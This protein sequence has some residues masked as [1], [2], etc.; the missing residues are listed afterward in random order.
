MRNV[1]F[2][3]VFLQ[4]KIP[5]LKDSSCSSCVSLVWWISIPSQFTLKIEKKKD[6]QKLNQLYTCN[7]H[8]SVYYNYKLYMQSAGYGRTLQDINIFRSISAGLH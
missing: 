7:V 4:K 2:Y 6:K 3:D 1:S 5:R 8:C